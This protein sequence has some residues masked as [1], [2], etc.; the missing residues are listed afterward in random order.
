MIF[1][2]DHTTLQLLRYRTH[3]FGGYIITTGVICFLTVCFLLI[4]S[5]VY[6]TL[7]VFTPLNL[8]PNHHRLCLDACFTRICFVSF[9][10]LHNMSIDLNQ[11]AH[12]NCI[13]S[14]LAFE[15]SLSVLKLSF[16][17]THFLLVIYLSIYL[18]IY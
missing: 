9:K 2:E 10:L 7:V 14:P 13:D 16:I 3:G 6:T 17:L 5:Y 18:S 8:E 12:A 1:K 4:L 11:L 15:V